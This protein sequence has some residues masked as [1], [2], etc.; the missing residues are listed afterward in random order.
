MSDTFKS[1]ASALSSNPELR[2]QVMSAGST[3]ERAS[4]LKGAGLDVPS[5]SD[6]NSGHAALEGVSGAGTTTAAASAGAAAAGC[7]A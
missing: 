1:V 5:H 3:E 2:Q 4:I 7:G 6:I